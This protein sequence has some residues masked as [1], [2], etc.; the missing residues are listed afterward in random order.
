MDCGTFRLR[1]ND[2]HDERLGAGGDDMAAH[3]DTCPAC[4]RY[5]RQ[6]RR[7]L[8]ELARLPL[9]A[10]EGGRVGDPPRRVAAP[11]WLALAATLAI[12]IALGLLFGQRGDDATVIAEPVTLGGGAEQR[13]A[14]AFESPRAYERVEFVVEL[15]P[16]I[17]LIG[18]PGQRSVRWEGRL[19]QGRSRLQLPLRVEPDAAG[20]RLVTRIVHDGGERR[21][22]VPLEPASGAG[23]VSRGRASV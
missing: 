10:V 11:R 14:V 13:I 12:G 16:G 9:P 2:W 5:D 8:D 19:A 7:M 15:P 4:A 6:M 17:E 3:R 20:G 1:W 23:S 22:V 21:L 18:F